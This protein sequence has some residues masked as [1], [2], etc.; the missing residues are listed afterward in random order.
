ME[1]F[2]HMFAFTDQLKSQ[3]WNCGLFG[4]N[5]SPANVIGSWFGMNGLGIGVLCWLGFATH[6]RTVRLE[7][8]KSGLELNWKDVR[9]LLVK[10]KS[11][12]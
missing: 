11:Q 2:E 5:V 12:N 4:T 10:P 1:W 3:N 9:H 7:Q 8:M 6:K